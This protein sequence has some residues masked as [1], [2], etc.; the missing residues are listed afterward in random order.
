MIFLEGGIVNKITENQRKRIMAFLNTR[1][2]LNHGER[3][4]FYREAFRD[5]IE[6]TNDLNFDEASILIDNMNKHPDKTE[7]RIAEILGWNKLL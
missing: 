1:M 6:S 7:D 5:E 2:N 3:I 4:K